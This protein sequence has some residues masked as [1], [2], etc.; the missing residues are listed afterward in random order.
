[1]QDVQ[2]TEEDKAILGNLMVT[3]AK[4]ARNFNVPGYRIVNNNGKNAY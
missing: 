4:I 2:D 1:L 3:A